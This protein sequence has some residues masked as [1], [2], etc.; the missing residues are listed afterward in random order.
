MKIFTG[1]FLKS[2]YIIYWISNFFVE[3]KYCFRKRAALAKYQQILDWV[4][5]QNIA[6]DTSEDLKLPDHLL[7]IT[8]NDLV[9]ALHT[10][11]DRYYVAM[12][13]N[14]SSVMTGIGTTRTIKGI[15]AC[16]VP[17]Q[18]RYLTKISNFRHRINILGEAVCPNQHKAAWAFT[19]LE[20]DK[21]YNDCL[22]AVHRY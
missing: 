12:M 19:N 11:E 16:D 21:R 18:S 6:L 7:G 3:L 4:K 2:L 13:I 5:T 1:F 15:L 10:L 9:Q 14:Y 20:V 8:H 22:F 17:L